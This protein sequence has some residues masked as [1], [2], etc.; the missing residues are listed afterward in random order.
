M[1]RS[2][3]E[4]DLFQLRLAR[5]YSTMSKDPSTKVGAVVCD[6]DSKHVFG[7][8]YNGFPS[9][10]EDSHE[11]LNTREKKLQYMDHAETNAINKA[12]GKV[13]GST[14]VVYP[15]ISCIKCAGSVIEEGISRVVTLDYTPERWK[16]EFEES[17]RMLKEA[18]IEV[19]KYKPIELDRSDV[20]RYTELW[21]VM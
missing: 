12:W 7:L 20:T 16:S 10:I 2:L 17:E 21:E 5:Q 6:S 13:H 19:T 14:I 1:K 4:W 9:Y 11:F 3:A 15:F 18:G 8:G